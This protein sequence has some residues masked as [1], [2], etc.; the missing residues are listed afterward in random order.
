MYLYRQRQTLWR[1]FV[2]SAMHQ[3][4]YKYL[5]MHMEET[6]RQRTRE[7]VNPAEFAKAQRERK[8]CGSPVRGTE[9]S[10]RTAS[11]APAQ[12]EVRAGAVL[13]GSRGP[14]HQAASAVLQ[15]ADN[16]AAT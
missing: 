8:K 11:L 10:D 9:E 6:A 2:K 1:M 5:A 15:L 13:P 12:T 7:L 14:E 4:G 16:T 3:W